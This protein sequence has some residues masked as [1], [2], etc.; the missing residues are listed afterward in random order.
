VATILG[1]FLVFSVWWVWNT[2]FRTYRFA[3][4]QGGIQV[5]FGHLKPRYFVGGPWRLFS[6]ET[7]YLLYSK[8]R[9]E[10]EEVDI[11]VVASDKLRV[12]IPVRV[13]GK[14]TNPFLLFQQEGVTTAKDTLISSKEV[15]EKLIRLALESGAA[16][17]A[18]DNDAAAF[19]E[20][21]LA[22][23]PGEVAP[24]LL[25]A[26][27]PYLEEAGLEIDR[28]SL[29]DAVD[30]GD[31]DYRKALVEREALKLEEKNL[32]QERVML[33]KL[34][35][36]WE[37]KGATKKEARTKAFRQLLSQKSNTKVFL[38][39]GDGTVIGS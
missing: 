1:A 10:I 16:D 17:L 22:D 32:E 28:V 33:D 13:F 3:E 39:E 2:L 8:E 29:R 24:S 5:L 37:S 27:N 14:I 34:I 21:N 9:F 6:I 7:K 31:L 15:G 30:Y 11:T 23:P 26:A 35:S 18:D 25:A 36:W 20:N 38:T 19:V 4:N 12:I